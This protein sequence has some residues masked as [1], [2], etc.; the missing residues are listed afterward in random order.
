MFHRETPNPISLNQRVL[1]SS[2]SASTKILNYSRILHSEREVT[3]S[4]D[5]SLGSYLG[6]F[7]FRSDV[8]VIY[9]DSPAKALSEK[10]AG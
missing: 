4:A 9:G 6:S 7:Y 3:A 5:L 2:P 8:F 1:G 10:A